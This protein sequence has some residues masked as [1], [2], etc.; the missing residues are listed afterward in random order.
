MKYI[1]YL[2]IVFGALLGFYAKYVKENDQYLLVIGIAMLMFGL[3]KISSVLSSNKN[4]KALEIKEE[5]E[6]EDN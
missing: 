6:N 1:P 3:Y 4:K 2:L 5:I